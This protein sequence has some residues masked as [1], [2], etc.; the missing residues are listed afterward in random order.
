MHGPQGG[1]HI[2]VGLRATHL[3]ASEFLPSEMLVFIAGEERARARPWLDFTCTER[4]LEAFGT[5]LIFEDARPEDLD[6][7]VVD[8]DA[9]VTD[10][11]GLTLRAS[12]TLVITD[13]G[14]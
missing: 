10:V 6:G 2:E 14:A 5:L 12:K 11:S 13:L 7:Q 8:I 9:S 4:G 3:D 1:F